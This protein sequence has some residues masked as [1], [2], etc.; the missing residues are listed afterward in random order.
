M[1]TAIAV[2]MVVAVVGLATRSGEDVVKPGAPIERVEYA[3]TE[4][5]H[6]ETML[7]FEP[8]DDSHSLRMWDV[9]DGVLICTFGKRDQTV[10]A[11][12]YFLCDE[13][14]KTT[15][16]EF[17][18]PVEEFRPQAREMRIVVPKRPDATDGR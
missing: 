15:R 2:S 8:G 10:I 5:G 7:A 12:E 18:F 9:G 1:K 13:R 16:K 11:I 4:A 17:I 3:M 14:P 6:G